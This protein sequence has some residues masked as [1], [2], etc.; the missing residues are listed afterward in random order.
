MFGKYSSIV[1]LGLYGTCAETRFRLSAKRT[2]P[3]DTAGATVQST[4]GSRGVWVSSYSLYC[5]GK[6]MFRGLVRHDGYPFHSPVAPSL[7]HTRVSM[8]HVIIIV[9]YIKI[10]WINKF[11]KI[12]FFGSSRLLSSESFVFSLSCLLDH[13][14]KH[15]ALLPLVSKY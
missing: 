11:R 12:K 6:A 4:T 7:S 13:G 10:R 2:G 14:V 1:Q 9:L 8:C 3:C 15:T 5:A